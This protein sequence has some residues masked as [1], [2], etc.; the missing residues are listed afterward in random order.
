VTD[1]GTRVHMKAAYLFD[2]VNDP[3]RDGSL[4]I[5][6]SQIESIGEPAAD[7]PA[8]VTID[9]GDA[10]ILPGLIDAHVHLT[11]ERA[12]GRQFPDPAL[13]ALRAAQD[14]ERIL[15]SGV[16]TVRDCG[17]Q[18]SVA[19]RTAITEGAARGPRIVAAGR[20]MSQ[21]GGHA[22]WHSAPFDLLERLND[23]IV[24]DG[25]EECRKAVRR[26]VR[27]KSDFIK[28]CTTGGVGSESDH[29]LDEHFTP[30]EIGVIVE[31]A[32]RAGRRVAAHAQGK[33]GILNAV[34]AGVDTIEHGYFLDAECIEAMLEH[35]T[36][37]VPT[38]GLI[39]IFRRNLENAA[40]LPPWRVTKQQQ[41]IE[42]MEKSF[43][44]AVAAGIPIA[45]GSD[46]FGAPGREHGRGYEEAI[47]MV[48]S[49]GV[50]PIQVLRYATT[51][52]AAALGLGNTTG[53][54][55]P[56]AAADVI[57]TPIAP[58]DSIE[59][60][61]DV[62]FVMKDGRVIRAPDDEQP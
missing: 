45:T 26:A 16:T 7:R 60:L 44:M 56:G 53:Q 11:G 20:Y 30:E 6:G 14:A 10:A 18:V 35:G 2:G 33:A 50:D 27:A 12:F 24:V 31:E 58:W 4:V 15:R 36:T 13:E 59:A 38:F 22:D 52:G 62:S 25:V 54:L 5:H 17:S 47:S 41:C 40:N 28:I 42:A 3:V 46:S 1:S 49:G 19:L 57:A 39:D 55:A 34:R 9:L 37:L 48:R 32:H 21:T 23:R 29:M 8:D 43:P 61:R 51:G